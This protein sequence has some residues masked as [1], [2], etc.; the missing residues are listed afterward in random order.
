MMISP[1][2][3]Y[4]SVFKRSGFQYKH[5]SRLFN[6]ASHNFR[7]K[8]FGHNRTSPRQYFV[9]GHHDRNGNLAGAMLAGT[10]ESELMGSD[11]EACVWKFSWLDFISRGHQNIKHAAAFLADKM[12][13]ACHEGI[14]MLRPAQ[15]QYLKFFVCNEFLQVSVDGPEAY[16]WK[17][18]AY[19]RVNLIGRRMG[20][21]ILD[22]L[23]DYF[24]LFRI[25]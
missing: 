20:A 8:S 6:V 2:C 11:L 12:L 1:P 3:V 21:I 24:E 7:R 25:S 18:F 22:G 9:N 5:C 13:M 14:E 19:P 10:V 4:L 17:A 23:P 16:V 15:H